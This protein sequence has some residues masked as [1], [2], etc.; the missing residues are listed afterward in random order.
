[1][2]KKIFRTIL[3]IS[4]S[5]MLAT[6]ICIMFVLQNHIEDSLNKEFKH[7]ANYIAKAYEKNGIDYLDTLPRMDNRITIIKANGEVIYDN[8]A[9]ILALDNHGKRPEII[10]A[11]KS[12]IGTSER[13]SSTF[14]EKRIYYAIKLK[15]DDFLRLS[16]AQSTALG[17]LYNVFRP[18]LLIFFIM[19]LVAFFLAHKLSKN[20]VTPINSIDFNDLKDPKIYDELHPL[21]TRIRILQASIKEKQNDITNRELQFKHITQ[22]MKEGLVIIDTSMNMVSLN[23]SAKRLLGSPEV[24][25][26]SGVLSLNRS[27]RFQKLVKKILL[28]ENYNIELKLGNRH[29]YIIG[30]PSFDQNR[31]IIGGVIIVIDNTEIVKREAFRRE[32]SANVSHELKTPLTS[33]SGF[34]EI[35]K[36]GL[37]KKDDLDKFIQNIYTEAQRMIKLVN[38]II[39]L[40]QLDERVDIGDTETINLKEIIN[41]VTRDLQEMSDLANTKIVSKCSDIY[42]EASRKSIYNI[43]YNL[44]ENAIKYNTKGKEVK[45]ST[46]ENDEVKGLI[47][48]DYGIGIAPDKHDRIFERFYRVDKGRSKEIQGTGLGLSIVKNA[49]II[50]GGSIDVQSELGKGTTMTVSFQK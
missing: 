10:E 11:Q 49:L 40:S 30:S 41:D 36:D 13:V 45:V 39:K 8:K 12:G 7:E 24:E 35:I 5:V 1:M 38:D 14:S 22:S 37:V 32:F 18:I 21:I 26:G 23:D 19:S 43:V 31:D 20:I 28:G 16:I 33:I 48:K 9:D 42:V 2:N 44:V 47:V 25:A 27:I 50:C 17:L 4:V 15:N 6:V 3:L 29:C 46:Y 34:A